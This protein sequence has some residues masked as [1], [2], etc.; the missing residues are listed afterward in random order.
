MTVNPLNSS[1]T[2]TAAKTTEALSG[3]NS[4]FDTFLTLLTT[5]LQNQDPLNPMDT[6][7]MTAQL[8]QF[9]QVEQQIAQNKNLESLIALQTASA[10]ASSV[11]Y[12]G[13]DVQ[14][15]GKSTNVTEDGT[16]W[17]YTLGGTAEAVTLNVLNAAGSLVYSEEGEVTAGVRHSFDWNLVNN[18]GDPLA[19]GTYTLNVSALDADGDPITVTTDSTG[20][21]TGVQSGDDG[22]ERLVG[23]DVVVALSQILKVK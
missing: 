19:P 16:T 1:T 7:E 2:P 20:T 9:S 21:V 12:I 3:L 5:Q 15:D 23:D 18:S 6:H 14:I 10:D 11:S 13:H 8:V 22:P 17:G 4:D